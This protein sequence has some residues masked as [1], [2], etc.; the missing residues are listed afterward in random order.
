MRRPR[1]RPHARVH[2]LG[3]HVGVDSFGVGQTLGYTLK[4]THRLVSGDQPL[5]GVLE[6]SSPTPPVTVATTAL[7]AARIS[8]A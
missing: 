7:A 1:P 3:D 6:A 5:L 2:S 4:Q 8:S